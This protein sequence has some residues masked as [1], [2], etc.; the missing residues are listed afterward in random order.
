MY[1][2]RTLVSTREAVS[3]RSEVVG[4]GFDSLRDRDGQM[5]VAVE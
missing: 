1:L 2:S 3:G 5:G 4:A